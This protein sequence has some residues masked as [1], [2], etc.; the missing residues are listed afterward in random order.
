M[1]FITRPLMLDFVQTFIRHKVGD[2]QAAHLISDAD[3]QTLATSGM[4]CFT[5]LSAA[6][7]KSQEKKP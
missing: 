1:N 4:L 5:I 7:E 6:Y 2:L 3:A